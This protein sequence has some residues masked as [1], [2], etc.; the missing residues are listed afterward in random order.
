MIS[1]VARVLHTEPYSKEEVL[2]ELEVTNETL[3]A[4]SLTEN[5]KHIQT[6]KL[7]QRAMHVFEEALRVQKFY[8]ECIRASGSAEGSLV[9]LGR[10]MAESHASLRDNYECSHPQMDRLVELSE[11][12]SFGARLTGAGWGGCIVALLTHSTVDNY[13]STIKEK[14]YK[15]LGIDGSE[16]NTLIFAT[17]PNQGAC[18]YQ[19][20]N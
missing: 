3:D 15:P 8:E 1:L 10:L 13:I 17:E 5:T 16:L 7:H 14:F 4:V 11:G 19:T 20:T 9:A 2:T 6:Y 18:I 12:L